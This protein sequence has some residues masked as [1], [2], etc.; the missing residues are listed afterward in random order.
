MGQLVTLDAAEV[1]AEGESSRILTSGAGLVHGSTMAERLDLEVVGESTIDNCFAVQP[2][3][4]RAS[5]PED[6]RRCRASRSS[7]SSAALI[8]L[9]ISARS[10]LLRR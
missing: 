3:P 6:L 9:P 7:Q 2:G 8:D 1:H 10:K 4:A 5:E